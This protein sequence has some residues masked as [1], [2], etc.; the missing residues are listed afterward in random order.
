MK[1]YYPGVYSPLMAIDYSQDIEDPLSTFQLDR[2]FTLIDW[3]YAELLQSRIDF[4]DL[5]EQDQLRLM[6]SVFP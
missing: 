1:Q 3:K 2:T 5:Q 6:F 4:E